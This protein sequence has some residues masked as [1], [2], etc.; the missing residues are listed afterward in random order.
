M[1]STGLYGKK[2]LALETREVDIKSPGFNDVIVKV[3]ACGI[4]GTDIN[5]LK[6]WENEPMPLGHEI[7]AEVV[8]LGEGVIDLKPGDSVVVE[9]CSMCGTCFNCKAGR[10]DLCRDMHGLN[11]YPGM[12][13][14]LCVRYNNLVKFDGMSHIDACL[15]EPLAVSLNA[16]INSQIPLNGSVAVLGCGPLGIMAAKVAKLYGAGFVAITEI[17]T[18]SSVGKARVDL[19]GKMGVDMIIDAKKQDI[20]GVIK[21]KFPKGI[22]RVIVSSPPESI[23]DALRIIGYGGTITFFGLHF[24]GRNKINVDIN[25][26]IFNKIT[27]QPFFAEPAM[28][29][30]LSLDLIKKGLIPAK[31]IITHQFNFSDAKRILSAIV[32]GSEPVI[33]AVML[34]NS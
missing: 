19:A 9:D 33:K 2:S 10:S 32:N 21:G 24:G 28:N 5:F 34:P 1:R 11:G 17:D 12:G 18:Q 16:V 31:D 22:D 3:H 26:L 13:Q 20:E 8:E 6:Q 30:N 7:A 14:Y 23:N 25:H 29:F 27:L 4:C 15:A